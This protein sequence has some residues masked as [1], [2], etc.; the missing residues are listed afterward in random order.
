MEEEKIFKIISIDGGGIKGLYSAS[1]LEKFEKKFNCK[2]SDHFDMICGTSTG[3]LIALA[4]SIKI[5]AEDI[6]KFYEAKGEI[7]FPKHKEISVPFF[8]KINRGL[9][10]QIAFGG[11]Y[12]NLGLKESLKEI[13]V[14]KKIGD[15]NNLLCI[16]SYSITEAKPKVF[17]YDHKEGGLSR[18]N[19]AK[20]IDIALA[21]SAAPTYLP[22]AE[23]PY[24]NNE[25]FVDGGVWANNPTL[26]GLL[27]ALN[28]FVGK[29]KKY[30]KIS[31]LSLSSLS[32]T[33]GKPTG[34]KNERSFKDWGAD[35]FETSMNGQSYFTD[36][37]MSKV[38]EI[39]D[40]KI[41]YLRIPSANISKEQE[42]LIQ[43]DIANKEAFNLMRIK[44]DDQALLFEKTKEIEYYFTT[45]KTYKTNG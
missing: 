32:I 8:G 34:L 28:N 5:S 27:E 31:I 13:F 6:R 14:D 12:S 24:F 39:S 38:K 44:A 4:L 17:K 29:G 40:I 3:G 41:D 36:F 7:I 22:M 2:T 10:K 42:S 30:D 20:M 16:P 9:W 23:L 1:I 15:S 25:Q 21:T 26:V 33:G 35:L 45:L 37:F 11:K 18:D 43:L 19:D